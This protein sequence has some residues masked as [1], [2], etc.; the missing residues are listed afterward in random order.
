MSTPTAHLEQRVKL[1]EIDTYGNVRD[2]DLAHVDAL[3][4]SIALRGLIVPLTVRPTDTGRF[5]LVAGFHRHAA[6]VKLGLD[7][8]A[9][10]V[11]DEGATADRAAENVVRKQLSPLEEA[12]AVKAMLDEGFTLDGSASVLGWSRSW[13]APGQRSSSFPAAR[14]R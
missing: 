4:G 5:A 9:V 12:R 6:C 2:L 13:S 14:R 10:T 1:S 7:E 8:V 11:R 3:A